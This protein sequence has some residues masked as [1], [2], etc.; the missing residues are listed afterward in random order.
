[1]PIIAVVSYLAAIISGCQPAFNFTVAILSWISARECAGRSPKAAASYIVLC[2]WS[3]CIGITS[4][5]SEVFA[6]EAAIATVAFVL[7]ELKT[8]VV[9]PVKGDKFDSVHYFY[10]VIPAIG[11]EGACNTAR[12]SALSEFG[13][14]VVVGG[15]WVWCVHKKHFAKV[16]LSRID[17]SCAVLINTNEPV[18][19]ETTRKLDAKVGTRAVYLLND[20]SS[21]HCNRTLEMVLISRLVKKMLMNLNIKA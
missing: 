5:D 7:W 9:K 20:C 3:L 18:N 19:N 16:P 12:P 2:I 4:I 13:G 10:G 14:R 11:M 8:L 6:V 21:L 1:M 15:G 17:I